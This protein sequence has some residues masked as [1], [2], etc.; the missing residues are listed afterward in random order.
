MFNENG[1]AANPAPR[2]RGRGRP[3]GPTP[4]GE[5]T[6]RR[7][8]RIAI[9]QI[10]RRGYGAATLRGI[11]AQAG[12]SPGLLYRYFPSKQAVVIAFYDELSAAYAARAGALPAGAWPERFRFAL[13]ESL[14]TLAP[15]R[16]TLAALVPVL[17]GDREGGLFAPATAFSRRRVQQVFVDAVVG[18]TEAPAPALAAPLGRLL[19]LAHLLLLLWWLLDRSPEQRATWRLIE[20][21]EGRLPLLGLALRLPGA[22]AL[23]TAADALVTDALVGE[24][25]AG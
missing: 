14:G 21:V 22:A 15:Q 1:Q 18:A 7:L 11:A 6:R 24:A 8:F 25:D 13:R 10:A 12:V 4:Q 17:V 3:A 16:G 9:R 5:R 2:R 19:Y 20:L 23:L